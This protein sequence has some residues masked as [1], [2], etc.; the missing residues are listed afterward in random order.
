MDL[1][2]LELTRL[3][4]ILSMRIVLDYLCVVTDIALSAYLYTCNSP[5]CDLYI[6]VVF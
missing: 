4:C 5:V 3:I 6:H 2:S 1:C